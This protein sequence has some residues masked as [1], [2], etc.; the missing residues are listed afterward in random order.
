MAAPVWAQFFFASHL[1]VF[2]TPT[3]MTRGQRWGRDSRRPNS[4]PSWRGL[5][6]AIQDLAQLSASRC[7]SVPAAS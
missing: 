2:L 1:E 3:S 7:V 4:R 6:L 5:A